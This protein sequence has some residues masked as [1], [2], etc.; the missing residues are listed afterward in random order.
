MIYGAKVYTPEEKGFGILIKSIFK[1]RRIIIF[2]TALIIMWMAAGVKVAADEIRTMNT[3]VAEAYDGASVDISDCSLE[4]TADYECTFMTEI[5]RAELLECIADGIGLT[6]DGNYLS[7]TGTDRY[8][9]TYS[10]SAKFCETVIKVIGVRQDETTEYHAVVSMNFS[11]E[12]AS[13]VDYYYELAVKAMKATGAADVRS[14]RIFTGRK[15]G[16]MSTK[17]CRKLAL[18]ISD[19]LGGKTIAEDESVGLFTLY[20]YTGKMQEYISVNK[21]KIDLQISLTYD[22]INDDTVIYVAVPLM[23]GSW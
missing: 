15:D 21:E 4:V 11:A 16:R 10:K 19:R 14:T 8:V 20:A 5:E 2:I 13:S 22:E 18:Q 12:G 7:T 9:C 1:S 17:Q 3:T 6:I 23:S